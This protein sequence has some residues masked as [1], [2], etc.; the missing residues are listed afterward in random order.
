MTCCKLCNDL[1][2]TDEDAPRLAFD[3]T[4]EGLS[5]SALQNG[6][7][8]CKVL[9][10]GLTQSQ[11]H[12]TQSFLRSIKRVY[13]RCHEQ[14]KCSPGSLTYEIYFN[15]EMPKLE[16]ELY[17]ISDSRELEQKAPCD[18]H[19]LTRPSLESH[20]A[21]VTSERTSTIV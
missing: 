10:E 15:N 6:C 2:K 19:I 21:K 1:S 17:S 14:Q 9:L 5:Q 4:V 8:C 12:D 3:F 18:T 7:V 13:V 11:R 16:L 20:S